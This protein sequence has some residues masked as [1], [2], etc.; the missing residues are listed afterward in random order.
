[1]NGVGCSGYS[2][3]CLFF[4]HLVLHDQLPGLVTHTSLSFL[5]L[6]H[7]LTSHTLDSFWSMVFAVSTCLELW[8]CLDPFKLSI[9][10]LKIWRLCQLSMALISWNA[11][12]ISICFY[13]FLWFPE[14][15]FYCFI[16]STFNLTISTFF[17]D[18]HFSC[19]LVLNSVQCSELP[20]WYDISLWC[21]R[22]CHGTTHFW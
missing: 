17:D 1:M 18:L 12:H 21:K 13:C 8:Y 9:L 5:L 2:V 16:I 11:G 22:Y 6:A 15:E 4:L 19:N 14:F 20:Y 3:P 10:V 7:P